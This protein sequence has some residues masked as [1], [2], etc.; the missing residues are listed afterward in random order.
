MLLTGINWNSLTEQFVDPEFT[1]LEENISQVHTR[2]FPQELLSV[3][4]PHL[5]HVFFRIFK[6]EGPFPP[7]TRSDNLE[8]DN[9]QI[10]LRGLSRDQHQPK[11][12]A[13]GEEQ[14]NRGILRYII[15]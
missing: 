5:A 6:G 15:L 1:G 8:V 11:N 12:N 13:F 3:Q 4:K 2:E 14:E 10:C 7:D 9:E